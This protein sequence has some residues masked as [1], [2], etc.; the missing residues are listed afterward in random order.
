MKIQA[1]IV[2][3]VVGIVIPRPGGTRRET[4]VMFFGPVILSQSSINREGL[5]EIGRLIRPQSCTLLSIPQ[6]QFILLHAHIGLETSIVKVRII[7]TQCYGEIGRA[8]CRER[9]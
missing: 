9:V 5:V 7:R 6:S 3:K 2:V 8:S 4:S 1:G